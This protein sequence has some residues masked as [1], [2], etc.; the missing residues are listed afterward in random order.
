MISRR[1][2]L[3]VTPPYHAGVVESAGRWMPLSF[4]YLAGVAREAGYEVEIYDAMTKQD[5][6]ETVGQRLQATDA[7]VIAVTAITSSLPLSIEVLKH[8]KYHHP[9][10]TTILGGVHPTFCYEEIFQS[11][12]DVVDIIVRGEGEESLPAVLRALA[13]DAPLSDIRGITFQADSS[14]ISTPHQPFVADL[15]AI[16]T[17]WDLI[18][19]DDYRYYVIPGSI[20]ASISTSRGCTF[21][22]TFCSQQKFWKKIWRARRP[23]NIVREIEMLKTRYG[24]NVFLVTDEYPTS[25][26]DRWELFLDL[27]IQRQLGVYLLMETR[28]EDIVRDREILWKYRMAGIV[29]I[30]IGVEATDQETLDI[31]KKDISV[32]QSR[33]AIRLIREYR[34][35]SE[36]S[37]VIG[38]PWETKESIA[39]TLQL[40]HHYNPDFAHFL[41]ITP[42]PYADMYPEMKDHIEVWDYSKYNLVEP[43]IRPLT[44]SLGE[45]DTAIIDCYKSYYMRKAPE[46]YTESDSFKRDY[47]KRSMH[48][49]M[50]NSFL[51]KLMKRAGA[52]PHS[53]SPI[54]SDEGQL[55]DP[56]VLK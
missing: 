3:L 35:I 55:I 17:A 49:I 37:F 53:F 4:V 13:N 52:D 41:A 38:F 56:E 50:K 32:E 14:I 16:P 36:T 21:G 23:E 43:I 19:W 51:T 31:V 27:L 12:G 10:I 7:D 40:A 20:L 9:G 42:W 25:D 11:H 30:Y 18:N 29:H 46:Y 2:L 8:A 5:S 6:I 15:D 22:C 1:K 39:N 33:E 47:L 24:A 45:I 44:M 48:L 28:V 26:P 54:Q 34:M